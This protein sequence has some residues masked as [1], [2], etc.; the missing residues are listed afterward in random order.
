MRIIVRIKGKG[1]RSDMM[2]DLRLFLRA[3]KIIR[4]SAIKKERAIPKNE[5]IKTQGTQRSSDPGESKAI[6]EIGA[7]IDTRMV[8]IR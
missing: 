3:N 7:T 1:R 5:S 8:A 6:T 4:M 2:S